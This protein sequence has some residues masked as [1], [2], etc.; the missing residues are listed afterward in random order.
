MTHSSC[1]DE[2]DAV[3]EQSTPE[4]ASR[5]FVTPTQT[6]AGE[7]LQSSC[8][9]LANAKVTGAKQSKLEEQLEQ[10]FKPSQL[11][12]VHGKQGHVCKQFN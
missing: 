8:R 11:G 4:N 7:D 1:S 5:K 2:G 9:M 6:A 12:K 10:C 3:D